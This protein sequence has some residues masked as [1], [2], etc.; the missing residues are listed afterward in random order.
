MSLQA[1]IESDFVQAYKAKDHLKVAVLRMLKTAIKNRQVELARPL[2]PL[3]DDAVLDVMLRQA[4][5][6]QES[7]AQ[8]RDAGRTDLLE[9]EAAELAVLEDI[10]HPLSRPRN[11]RPWSIRSR[12]PSMRAA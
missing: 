10:C 12:P 5:Q 8:F 1:R 7:I 3:S 9:K 4:K 2:E 11:W 6:R